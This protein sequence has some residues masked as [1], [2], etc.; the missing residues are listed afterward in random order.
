MLPRPWGLESGREV[1][2][3]RKR[4]AEG[5]GS[6]GTLLLIGLGPGYLQGQGQ[7]ASE[8]PRSCLMGAPPW[9][10]GGS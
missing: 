1:R 8:Q 5:C 7:G 3:V 10:K 4:K 9:A 6:L 2:Q